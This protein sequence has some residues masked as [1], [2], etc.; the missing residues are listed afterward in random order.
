MRISENGGGAPT[1]PDLRAACLA[2]EDGEEPL[3]EA[4]E[5]VEATG[6]QRGSA[7]SLC[8]WCSGAPSER[9]I[10]SEASFAG[11][12]A[13]ESSIAMICAGTSIDVGDLLRARSSRS[14]LGGVE[15]ALQDVAGAEVEAAA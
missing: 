4:V 8:S 10:W 6:Q 7:A 2:V 5:L 14:V 12:K 3:G 11:S 15:L 9:I 13:G 1:E